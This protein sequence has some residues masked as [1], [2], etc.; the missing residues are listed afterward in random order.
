MAPRGLNGALQQF[1]ETQVESL[2]MHV[3]IFQ[4]PAPGDEAWRHAI[5]AACSA[6]DWDYYE[7]F[8]DAPLKMDP[9]RNGVVVTWALYPAPTERPVWIIQTCAPG[10][11]VETLADR[12]GLSQAEAEL[13]ASSRFAEADSLIDTATAISVRS[14]PVVIPGMGTVDPPPG[15]PRIDH[16][17]PAG[18]LALYEGARPQEVEIQCS[19]DRLTLTSEC[20]ETTAD[21]ARLWLVGRRRI[22]A[23]GPDIWV[24]AGQWTVTVQLILDAPVGATLGFQWA[25]G[26]HVEEFLSQSGVYLLEFTT[27]RDDKILLDLRISLMVPILNGHLTVGPLTIRRGR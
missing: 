26:D 4:V 8:D 12:Y 3:C 11:A 15:L 22:L 5:A 13:H 10:L 16:W 17:P 20:V 6:H 18:L 1:R 23:Q 21:G 7:Q 25:Q 19:P 27:R 14:D 24:P 2:T 9:E